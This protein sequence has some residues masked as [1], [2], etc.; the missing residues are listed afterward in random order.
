MEHHQ[1]TDFVE[2]GDAVGAELVMHRHIGQVR[3]L[4][5]ARWRPFHPRN[6]GFTGR[7]V[8]ARA[9]CDGAPYGLA[10]G[11]RG[12]ELAGGRRVLRLGR[13]GPAPAPESGR[14]A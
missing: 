14:M 7:I 13:A 10:R 4:W 11:R 9:R 1:L 3:G 6:T 2:Y 8:R 12:S 5:A